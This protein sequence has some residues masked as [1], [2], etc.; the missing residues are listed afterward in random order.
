MKRRLAYCIFALE[1][2]YLFK[3]Y[4]TRDCGLL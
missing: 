2:I 1:Y 3:Y 4:L